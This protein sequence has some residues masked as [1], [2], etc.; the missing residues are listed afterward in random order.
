MP[1]IQ[2][3]G[4]SRAEYNALKFKVDEAMKTVG[5]ENEA[6]TTFFPSIVESCDG[7][8]TAMP[9]LHIFSSQLEHVVQIQA[10]LCARKI[11]IDIEW[12]SGGFI[13][14]N[15]GRKKFLPN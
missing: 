4:F 9:Y 15:A 3:H 6:V 14:Q 8:R 10:A 7:E 2:F 5:L 1:N 11:F 12:S 13:D